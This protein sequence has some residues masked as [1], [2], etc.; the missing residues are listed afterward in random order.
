MLTPAARLSLLLRRYVL[1]G[2]LVLNHGGL[3]TGKFR[4]LNRNIHS[5]LEKSHSE[6]LYLNS[7][8]KSWWLVYYWFASFEW[9]TK[10]MVV[11]T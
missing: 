2:A 8:W 3:R 5:H 9:Q 4:N 10:A 6:E 1:L 11:R 7:V